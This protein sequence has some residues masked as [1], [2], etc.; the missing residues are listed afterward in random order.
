MRHVAVKVGICGDRSVPTNALMN[1]NRAS[2]VMVGNPEVTIGPRAA[3]AEKWAILSL[4]RHGSPPRGCNVE[5][6]ETPVN[7]PILGGWSLGFERTYRIR[8]ISC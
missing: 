2:S 3:P 1:S 7:R 8:G 5:T 6:D 4:Y